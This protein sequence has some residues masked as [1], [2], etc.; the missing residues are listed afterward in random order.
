[1]IAHCYNFTILYQYYSILTTFN[2]LHINLKTDDMG[3]FK[4]SS[5]LFF[6][7]ISTSIIFV[8][9]KNT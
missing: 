6:Y 8:L 5:I 7:I 2:Y 3:D 9:V 4:F 1:M